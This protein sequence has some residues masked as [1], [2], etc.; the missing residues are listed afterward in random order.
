VNELV[1]KR[2]RWWRFLLLFLLGVLLGFAGLAWYASTDSFQAMVR[3]RMVAEL[4]RVTGGRVELA[5]FHTIPFRLRADIRNLTI[6]GR[7]SA[8]ETPYIHLDRL[9][10]DINVI[11]VF[12][13]RFG[14]HSVVLE[15]PVIHIIVYPDGTTNQPEPAVKKTSDQTAVE[16]L[17]GLRIRNL[18]VRKGELIWNDQRVPLD[19]SASD[20][21]S[22]MNYSFLRRHYEAE[23]TLGKV[24]TRIQDYRPFSWRAH[25]QFTLARDS[26]EVK[27][28]KV[29]SGA[30]QLTFNGALANFRAPSVKGRYTA[31]LD[32][33]EVAGI[34]RQRALRRGLVDF[35]GSGQW[36]LQDF[37]AEGALAARELEWRD[38]GLNLQNVSVGA[39]FD[40]KPQR[41]TLKGIES[42]ILGGTVSGEAE[43]VGWQR[44]L[45]GEQRA[46]RRQRT[47]SRA[48]QESMPRG[49]VRL[50]MGGLPLAGL[51]RAF[52]TRALPLERA[53]FAGTLGGTA[54]IFWIGA[55][56]D[57][58]TRFTLKVTPPDRPAGP[59]I[60]LTLNARG[61]YR[62][63]RD[64]LEVHDASIAT[65]A[66]RATAEGTLSSTAS[67]KFLALTSDLRELEPLLAGP[68]SKPLPIAL[69]GRATFSGNASGRVH[70]IH[71]AG[72]LQ[73]TDFDSIAPAAA[74]RPELRVHWDSA[75][76]DLQYSRAG[77][78]ARNALLVHGDTE[79][80]FDV[81]AGLH[82]GTFSEDSP[83][84]G[85]LNVRNGNIAEVLSLAGYS[86]PVDGQMNLT[87]QFSGSMRTPAGEGHVE[88]TNATTYGESI[89][90]LVSDIRFANGEAQLTNFS[91]R[92]GNALVTGDAAYQLSS[93]SYRINLAGKNFDLA[94]IERLQKERFTVAGRL[95]FTA[96]GTGTFDV[97]VIKADLQLRDLT[98]NDER[99]GDFDLQA[100]TQGSQL[101]LNGTSNFREAKLQTSGTVT[102]R[103]DYP[104][105]LKLEFTQLDVDPLL[106][107]Y[108]RGQ[109]TGHSSVAGN[110]T[111]RGPLRK[112]RE[113]VLAANF[114]NFS[115]DV[116]K[117]Q[118][119]NEGP[120]RVGFANQTLQ[121]EQ[122]HLV[123]QGTD[124]TA[125]GTAQFSGSHALDLRADG[126]IN[127]V[128][129]QT[130]APDLTSS[131]TV[132]VGLNVTGSVASPVFRGQVKI[133]DGS[134]S[135]IDL[136]TGLS[137]LNG[138]LTFNENQL[139]VESLTARTGGGTLNVT[140]AISYYQR[141]V[142]FDLK[143]TAQEV[144]LR[145]PPGISSTM[146]ADIRLTGT[147]NGATLSGD[148][149]V[150]K[151]AMTP[152]FD[153][154]SYLERA[155][156]AAPVPQASSPMNRLKLDLHVTTTP[157][158]QMQTA[159]AKLSGDADLRVRGSAARPVVLGR[160][161]ILE[162]EVSF[163]GAKYRLE[164]GDVIFTNPARIEPI[165]DLEA[166]TRVSDYDVSI[167]VNGTADKLNVNYRSEP[168]L[169]SADII[170]LLALGRTREE[171]ASLQESTGSSLSG[172]AS[173]LI[174]S[175]ALN[176]TVS[177]R[178][179]RL[180]GISRIKIDPQGLP[181]ATNVV[182]G[183][184]VTIE[185]QVASN[186][187]LTY[188]TN[189]AVASQQVI[190]L[191]YNVTRA[192]SVVALRDQNG[193][194]SFDI[195][196]R[197]R[198]K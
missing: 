55:P 119:R 107:I 137:Q 194:V 116:D 112:P 160:I 139:Q 144:R 179:Q 88:I 27:D 98:L 41:I 99:V 93:K 66:T 125:R 54:D 163:N 51:K 82:R 180:F 120:V 28:L 175:E 37:S 128:L 68:N 72:N 149:T 8:S 23:L 36:S 169:P 19:F 15:R 81:N 196:I 168:P 117:I 46:Q 106:R 185:Q 165:L 17:F 92:Q 105:D 123:G 178:V 69:H 14:F 111:V 158:L 96:Q 35:Q 188:S 195:K 61:V 30:N 134:F 146:N 5:E 97:P 136:P 189:V 142:I 110:I 67:V 129:A 4:E 122:M 164:R 182:R 190:Q 191:E 65:P 172:A 166:S 32:L 90:K 6:H 24:D 89:S 33:S 52:N 197:K 103:D 151:L 162:G 2:R 53:R 124:L 187:T 108:L 193:V 167:G 16:Q 64:E 44:M 100:S 156:L 45:S 1:P 161:D 131:G 138:S 84:T 20:V 22:T 12:D 60:P 18:E 80:R 49:S 76:A 159:M 10:A 150:M 58:E 11:S 121:L 102:L 132:T 184:Q 42:R 143:G 43:V 148:L 91:A 71:L 183:P 13:L 95:D 79:I 176:A 31:A 170:A 75:T 62:G 74:A 174:L 145:Y 130:W 154:G 127:M 155:K 25:A 86:Y 57:A 173:N 157:E 177:S 21:V 63:S 9:V 7:E 78:V 147:N 141:Q 56:R 70:D 104:A 26:V 181:S 94:R 135:Y 126:T 77:I 186:V 140:G 38:D 29:N 153:F 83:V 40:V 87:A 50:R 109:V 39:A 133:A 115:A 47:L 48:E 3:K 192:V 114:T 34:L 118:V 198:K 171:S 59:D 85:H 152:G 73:I 101:T 113:L